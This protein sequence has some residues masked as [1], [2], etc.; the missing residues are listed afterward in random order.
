MSGLQ[1]SGLHGYVGLQHP[2]PHSASSFSKVTHSI[3]GFIILP[4]QYYNYD[5]SIIYR[6]KDKFKYTHYKKLLE[7]MQEQL[8]ECKN[9]LGKRKKNLEKALAEKERL[10]KEKED[11]E[12][13]IQEINALA[14]C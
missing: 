7:P 14:K 4:P 8:E 10:S 12:K 11:A 9:N 5:N 3:V 1:S 13:Q 6:K 2:G